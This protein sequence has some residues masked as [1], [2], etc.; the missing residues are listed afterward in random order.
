[1]QIVQYLSQAIEDINERMESM[2]KLLDL[3]LE[4]RQVILQLH[5]ELLLHACNDR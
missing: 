2:E 4:N 5:M 1:M 3:S